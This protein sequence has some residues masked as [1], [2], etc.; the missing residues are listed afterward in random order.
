MN[1]DI[2]KDTFFQG[3]SGIVTDIH[4]GDIPNIGDFVEAFIESDFGDYE[5]NRAL[6]RI[7][8]EV[9][10]I[11]FIQNVFP[12]GTAD[13]FQQAGIDGRAIFDFR[14]MTRNY[15]GKDVD[16]L[17]EDFFFASEQAVNRLSRD[18]FGGLGDTIYGSLVSDLGDKELLQLLE[19]LNAF[20]DTIQLISKT[21]LEDLT[22][23]QIFEQ[24]SLLMQAKAAYLNQQQELLVSTGKL[25][26]SDFID[27]TDIDKFGKAQRLVSKI[28]SEEFGKASDAQDR[29]KEDLGITD[30]M[31]LGISETIDNTLEQSLQNAIDGFNKLPETARITAQLFVKNLSEN[32]RIQDEFEDAIRELSIFAPLVA[33][34]LAEQGPQTTKLAKEF[35]ERPFLAAI[36]EGQ[37]LEAVGPELQAQA[38]ASIQ[39]ALDSG[40]LGEAGQ[41][42][43]DLAEGVVT[44]IE[45]RKEDLANIFSETLIDAIEAAGI[46]IQK[47]SPSRL[48][49]KQLGV[50]M[51]D[52]VIGGIKSKKREVEEAFSD[53]LTGFILRGDYIDKIMSDFSIYTAREDAKRGI[54]SA[55]SNRISS[56]QRLNEVLRAQA[57]ITD[58]LNES[59]KNLARLEREG[60]KGVITLDEEI[61]LLRRKVELENK[62]EKA[63][64]KKSAKEL[65]AIQRA[66]ENIVDLRAMA[67][68]GVI[69]NLELQAAEEDLA[70]LKG[71]DVT[72]DERKLAILELAQTERD[73]VQAREDALRISDELVQA[74]EDNIRL[75]D[76]EALMD[77][78]VQDA[79]NNVA[80][81][82]EREV[83]AD[84]QL[85]KARN[86]FNEAM[87][88]G[89]LL[90]SLN[91][92]ASSYDGITDA[93][94]NTVNASKNIY[95]IITPLTEAIIAAAAAKALIEKVEADSYNFTGQ[96]QPTT[97]FVPLD[98]DEMG[99][100]NTFFPRNPSFYTEPNNSYFPRGK[101]GGG[102]TS[103]NA[104]E[105]S[106]AR[107]ILEALASLDNYGIG[108]FAMGGR[109]K[110][111]KYGG[112]GDPM[113]RALVGEYG[114]E[115]VKFI[116]GNGFMVKPLGT[117]KSGTVVN[118]LNVNVTGVPSD[119]I[120][121][122][123]AAIQISKALNKLDKEGS[124]GTGLR[125]N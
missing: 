33:K 64:G 9:G 70:S 61:S 30:E 38:M 37:L 50:P 40:E 73:L 80:A 58:R 123:K 10:I 34:E 11:D 90:N 125:R 43:I 28:V 17:Y 79:I 21:D 31:L 108:S 93:I 45:S 69:S 56:E 60:A 101:A 118:N 75:K 5:I 87:A 116:P 98:P 20:G 19:I 2:F 103:S 124:S 119:P 35:L 120:S 6:K 71:E 15:R 76:E 94:N 107:R 32:L 114:P 86:D 85:E 72:E 25:A 67:A 3:M 89:T 111:Y 83:E 115:E 100:P 81:A 59:N 91:T 84:M 14:E 18:M 7:Q 57:S 29:L 4:T 55:L 104:E 16:E 41:L 95:S 105:K 23:S 74:R 92:V 113:T 62:I 12:R 48:T 52:G 24:A 117:G 49:F 44:G 112:R 66:E 42:G 63:E 22:D 1:V 109:V 54:N 36:A 110:K 8:D 68:K 106:L 39:E 99:V 88:T 27:A 46:A 47:G 102:D 78:K 96:T 53:V 65:L 77:T 82:K 51:I 26:Q 97:P 121:A 122:R 13:A